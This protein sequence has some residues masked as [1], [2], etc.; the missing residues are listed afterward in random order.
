MC[1]RY[2]LYGPISRHRKMP[3]EA[4][5]PEWWAALADTINER[6]MRFNVAPTDPMPVIGKS[7]EGA[8]KIREARW[9]LV[10]YWA[11]DSKIGHK[12]INARVETVAGKPMF[13]EAFKRRRCLVPA[14]GYFE[15]KPEGAAKQPYFIH[16]ADDELLM[17]AGLWEAWRETK[18]SEPLHTYTII[19]GPP[20][21]VSGDIHDRAPV[22]LPETMWDAWLGAD[23]AEASAML[24]GI[25]EP[26]LIYHAVSKAVGSPKNDAPGLVEPIQA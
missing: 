2:A 11:K 17:F 6:P 7:R 20:G 8:I 1:G 18:E 5:L 22:I 13:R 15:W 3:D 12:A 4:A 25:A 26:A 21:V 23:A 9:G 14:T 10:P 16:A 19:V 24:E